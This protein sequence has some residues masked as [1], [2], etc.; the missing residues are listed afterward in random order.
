LARNLQLLTT[1]LNPN[2]RSSWA[3]SLANDSSTH[4]GKS[5]FDNRI[6]IHINGKLYNIH[7]IAIPMFETHTGE[8]MYLLITR[9]LDI[10]CP[11]WRTQLLGLG[12]DG[13]S[14]MTGHLQGV[15]TR[16]ASQ[17]NNKIYRVWCGLHQ[18]DLVLKHAYTE[19]WDNE[20]VEIMKKFIQHLRQQHALIADMRATCPQLTTRWLVMGQV[21]KW[22]LEKRIRL[23]EYI[24][25]AKKSIAQAPPDWWWVVITGI[26]AL[27]D[28]I[29]PVFVK[30][31]AQNLLISTQTALLEGLAI[32]LCAAVGIQGPFSPEEII[33]LAAGFNSTY[34]RWSVSY[35]SVVLFIEGLG[36]YARRTLQ[37]LPH[38]LQ[39]KVIQSIG[40]LATTI[41]EGIVNIQVERD[42]KNHA[43]D[44]IPPVLPHELVKISTAH[45]GNTV[46]DEHLEQL[47]HSWTSED[48]AEIENQHRQLCTAY[49]SEPA[50][51]SALDSYGETGT[52][53]FETGWSI[54]E[55]RFDILRDFCGGIATVFANTASVESDFSVL[56]WEKD[57]YRL[58]IT[59]LSLEGI[60]QCKQF[61]ILSHLVE[62]Q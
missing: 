36:I 48:I 52:I 35:E 17:S 55:G 11:Q 39:H 61:E 26:S 12:S 56:G 40:Q 1:I 62:L 51:K 42:A 9:F 46:V 2:N 54:V 25:S 47:K 28:I 21:C 45:Y 30:L 29:N 8:N 6:R 33:E 34:G 58:S 41:V 5:Y 37:L 18:L 53:S 59:D 7:A 43:A 49:R 27:T 14:A 10:V 13:A 20:V 31:Q 4:Y 50:L 44:D 38:E 24:N 57:T 16:I 32:D 60:M 19:L 15:V 3:F 22:L 23:F